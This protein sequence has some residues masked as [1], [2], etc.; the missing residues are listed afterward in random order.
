ML[1]LDQLDSTSVETEEP[2]T[3]SQSD[4]ATSFTLALRFKVNNSFIHWQPHFLLF[5]FCPYICFCF[6]FVICC[7]LVL[8]KESNS[9]KFIHPHFGKMLFKQS[10]QNKQNEWENRTEPYPAQSTDRPIQPEAN[11]NK[12]WTWNAALITFRQIDWNCQIKWKHNIILLNKTA[13]EP[14]RLI[15]ESRFVGVSKPKIRNENRHD[16]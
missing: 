2:D 13:K 15:P 8:S 6:F 3:Q 10:S 5:F 7:F 9:M 11:L 4:K 14:Q 16:D 1:F 12:S